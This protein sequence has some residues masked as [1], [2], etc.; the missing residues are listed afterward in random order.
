ME[1]IM[2]SLDLLELM[3][4]DMENA[5]PLYRPT[6]FWQSGLPTIINDLRSNGFDNFRCHKSANL[7][8]AP[9]YA[10]SKLHTIAR[11]LILL[12]RPFRLLKRVRRLETILT[13]AVDG[14]ANANC[15]YK[16][17]HSS[18]KSI[19]S[20]WAELSESKIGA[21]ERFEFDGRCYSRSFLNY[22]L[23]LIFLEKNF[24]V[25]N[26]RSVLEIGG[27][28]GTLG[29]I[30]LK[31]YSDSFYI[32]IDIPPVA[33]VSSFYLAKLF[34]ENAVLT[35]ERSREM[36][37]I[38]ITELRKKYRCAVLCP[39]QLPRLTGEVDLFVNYI[40]FQEMEP[41][42]VQNYI[43]HVQP[44]TRSFVLLRNSKHGKIQVAK[45]GK[46]GVFS[47]ITTDDLD[48]MFDQFSLT[49]RNSYIYGEMSPDGEFES[50]VLCLQR[51]TF[52]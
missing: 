50:E 16:I 46:V 1:H 33:A 44:L 11:P 24:N 4:S 9:T 26:V 48:K 17:F 13:H 27:G 19:R 8:Y 38:D 28:Y 22:L 47:P 52:S 15:Q 23:G 2:N 45:E 21:G 20:P 43:N 6:N 14:T 3:L 32:D 34:G 42:V 7:F 39:W 5:D 40:S 10:E 35:Y 51:N 12:L 41:E 37:V 31:A 36:Q 30:Y 18:L 29:E 25:D 49:G